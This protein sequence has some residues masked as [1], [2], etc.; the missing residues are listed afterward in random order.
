MHLRQ[1]AA[2]T[3]VMSIEGAEK[4]AFKVGWAFDYAMRQ[5]H[6]NQSSLPELEGL[7]YKICLHRLWDTARQAFT[8]EQA[9]LRKF[10]VNRHRAN[11]EVIYG[12][13]YQQL[14]T[15]WIG[16]LQQQISSRQRAALPDR[17]AK[18]SPRRY[19]S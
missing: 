17:Q 7:K 6:F 4:V 19:L 12:I 11:R 10:D 9:I 13:P 8:M 14:E 5:Q 3:Y 16:Y 15:A 2:Y 18:N 1:A